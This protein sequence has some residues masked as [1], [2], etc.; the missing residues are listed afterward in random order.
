VSADAGIVFFAAQSQQRMV[1]GEKVVGRRYRTICTRN[2]EDLGD[3][4]FCRGNLDELSLGQDG[5]AV[6]GE[7]G[8]IIEVIT[9]RRF[10]AMQITDQ[11]GQ[12]P[13]SVMKIFSPLCPLSRAK[14]PTVPSA[15]I[16]TNLHYSIKPC[17][18]A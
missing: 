13:L 9:T 10:A 16:K 4:H 7:D 3:R 14:T 11:G 1:V 12:I 18:S 5:P 2:R 15:D 6:V 17:K 8:K